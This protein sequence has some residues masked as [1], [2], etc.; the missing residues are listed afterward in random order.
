VE[1]DAGRVLREDP[2][3]DRPDAGLFGVVDEPLEERIADPA[4][5]R[6]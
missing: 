2:G 1:R 6:G 4:A 3:L 5:V